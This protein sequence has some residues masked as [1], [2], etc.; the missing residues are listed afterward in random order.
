LPEITCDRLAIEQIIGNLVENA[1]KYMP[2]GRSGRIE[3]R[4]Q[5]EGDRALFEVADNGRGIDP[6]DHE[7]I[8]DLF[9]RSG[10]QDQ[11]GEG[12][13]LAHTRALA[14]RLGGTI[15]VESELGR[16]ATFRINLPVA[17][18]AEQGALA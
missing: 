17:F 4:G 15:S 10:V 1:I 2:P 9:R 5:T 18:G 8:F 3:I 16:G 14:Y 11:P 7:R 12:I 6:K 13:G